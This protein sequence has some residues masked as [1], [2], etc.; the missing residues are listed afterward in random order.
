MS[1]LEA[2]A[3]IG[4]GVAA[5]TINAVVGSGTLIT[6]PLLLALGYA[7]VTANVTSTVGLAPGSISGAIG[8]RA[9]LENQRPAITRLAPMSVLGALTGATLLL[10]LPASWFKAIVPAI[11]A[12]ALLLILI[13]PRLSAWVLR[14]DPGPGPVP[15]RRAGPL[16]LL[17]IYAAGI[18][19]GYFGA[20]QGILLIAILGSLVP[21]HLQRTNALK[22]V[23]GC[24][25]NIVSSLFFILL[26]DV[27]WEAVV[28]LAVGSA[29]GGQIGSRYGRKLSPSWLRA[30]IVVVGVVAIGALLGA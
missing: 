7:P 26:A 12:L 15:Q 14:H 25:V 17:C 19:G 13:Q 6:F 23:L 2:I 3:I 18:Y 5:G 24:F 20:A 29:L 11:I 21:D 1:L 16:T 27:A 8:Y 28:L 9:E 22:N 4:A 30:T 10:V